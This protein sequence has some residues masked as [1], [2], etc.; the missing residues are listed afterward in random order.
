MLLCRVC[1]LAVNSDKKRKPKEAS[2]FSQL[3]TCLGINLENDSDEIHPKLI[4]EKCRKMLGNLKRFIEKENREY[5]P[6][7]IPYN[8]EPHSNHQCNICHCDQKK[9]GRKNALKQL[10][11]F[12]SQSSNIIYPSAKDSE[13]GKISPE[14]DFISLKVSAEALGFAV[15]PEETLTS[16]IIMTK[17]TEPVLQLRN[18]L[19][20]SVS[21]NKTWSV[22]LDTTDISSNKM[23]TPIPSVVNQEEC[24]ELLKMCSQLSFCPGNH[25][26][27][28]LCNS[29][30]EEGNYVAFRD[31]E[32]LVIANEV[33]DVICMALDIDRT[34][35]HKNCS[36]ILSQNS[37][38]RCESCLKYRPTLVSLNWKLKQGKLPLAKREV[39]PT[40][41]SKFP[42]NRMST[43]QLSYKLDCQ[44][45]K[46]Q[47]QKTEIQT[48]KEENLQLKTRLDELIAAEGISID[49][50]LGAAFESTIEG[51]GIINTLPE[52]SAMRLLFE[53]QLKQSKLKNSK[54]M[55]WHPIIIR[56]CLG[57]YH[58]SPTAYDFLK[59]TSFLKLP[60]KSTLLDY[61]FYTKPGA[62]FNPDILRK[63]FEEAKVEKLN[64]R[65]KNVSILMDEMKIKSELVYNKSTGK[66]IG[67]VELDKVSN[68]IEKLEGVCAEE[69]KEKEVATHILAF[70]VRGIYSDLL[71]TFAHFPTK[72]LTCDV[73]FPLAWNAVAFVESIGLKV[74]C[75]VCDGASPNR[76]FYKMHLKKGDKSLPYFAINL[77]ATDRKIYL[78][79]DVPH[80]IK[81]VR[82][83]WENSHGNRNTR[84]LI[85]SCMGV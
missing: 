27:I 85:V 31:R 35:R 57:I 11:Q 44:K 74:R 6:N 8:F 70:M 23:F 14:L 82:N 3:M 28:E 29:R 77:C 34:V 59:K 81:T 55:R 40:S 61:T 7:V 45:T 48:L 49:K 72:S 30:R 21:N 75:F 51:G 64:S 9:A 15:I 2:E 24:L 36:M 41:S 50:T 65:T 84:N 1:G 43:E 79:C 73:I 22:F 4:C 80:L 66:L 71:F 38:A 54:Q 78:I 33:C 76:K 46:V 60:H 56:W 42:H 18:L 16:Y 47:N 69:A 58:T 62:G 5:R 83:N 39:K 67:F 52:G 53:E 37:S 68:E 10:N 26:F 32:N 17:R 25:D 20:I 13:E 19:T 12:T 63:L